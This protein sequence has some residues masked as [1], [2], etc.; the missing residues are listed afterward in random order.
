MFTNLATELGPHPSVNVSI[1]GY[2]YIGW[3]YTMGISTNPI[4]YPLVN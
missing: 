1:M 4:K 3:G 2:W